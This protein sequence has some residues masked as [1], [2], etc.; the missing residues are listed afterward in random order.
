MEHSPSPSDVSMT[1][2]TT[3]GITTQKSKLKEHIIANS[4][5][6]PQQDISVGK[7]HV[8]LNLFE[9]H[10]G[11]Q[12]VQLEILQHGSTRHDQISICKT[13]NN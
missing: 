7:D 4:G 1:V 6:Y 9:H 11:I 2:P 8:I 12:K 3:A 13:L 10:I 5:F